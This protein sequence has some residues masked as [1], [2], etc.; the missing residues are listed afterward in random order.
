MMVVTG[1][2]LAFDIAHQRTFV[3]NECKSVPYGLISVLV[4][5]DADCCTTGPCFR[6]FSEVDTHNVSKYVEEI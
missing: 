1:D 2:W 6:H 4:C 3:K 5:S